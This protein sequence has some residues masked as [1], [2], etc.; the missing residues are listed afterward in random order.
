MKKLLSA[1]LIALLLQTGGAAAQSIRLRLPDTT[2]LVGSSFL[3][4]VYADS[5]FTGLNVISYQVQLNYTA[6]HLLA[7]SLI[8]AG[9]LSAGASPIA[10]FGS[11]GSVTVAAASATP[12][13]GTGI[14]FYVR[15]RVISATGGFSST[16]SFST[17]ANTYLNQGSPALSFRNGNITIPALPSI[18]VNPA[19]GL[20]VVGDTL[21]FSASGGRQP[22]SWR[23][24][25]STRGTIN[26]LTPNTARFI[27][28]TSGR[29]RVLATDSNGF[30]GQS[31]QE[32]I[33]HNFR[34]WTR[35]SSRLQGTELLLPVY[36]SSLTP[37]NILSGS[38]DVNL[39]NYPGMQLTGIERNGTLLAAVNQTFFG[40]QG[41]ASWEVSFANATAVTGSGIL[42]YLRIA[43]PNL[44][45]SNYS[46][47]VNLA[48]TLFNQSLTAL[49]IG[50]NHTAIA[51]PQINITPNTAELVAGENR[52]FTASNGLGA[53]RWTVSD[54]SLAT[55][56]STGLLSA[57]KGGVV[58]VTATDSVNASRTTGNIQLYDTRMH[59]RDTVLIAGDTL[60]DVAVFMD[61]L[62]AG[63]SITA[64]SMAFDFN[65]SFLQP[66]SILQT[67]TATAGWSVATNAIGSNRFSVA[68]AGTSPHAVAANLFYIRFKVLPGFT[69]NNITSL[70]NIQVTLNEGNPNY[71][72]VNGQIRSLPCTPVATVTPSGNVTFCSNQPTQLSGSSGTAYQY[73]WS[74]NGATIAGANSRLFTPTQS[75]NYTLRV[76]LNSSCF[77]VSDTVRVTINPSPIAQIL[78]YADT[79]HACA[80][81]TVQLR[82][83]REAGYSLQWFRNGGTISGATDTLLK[84]VLSGSY[85]VRSTLNGC[86]TT[87]AAQIVNIRTLPAKPTIIVTGSPTCSGDSA[88]LRIPA[89]SLQLQWFNSAGPIS[90]ATDTLLRVPA[91]RYTLRLTNTFGC[92]IY[93]DSVTVVA[94]TASA[95]IDP[96]GP[97]TFCQGGNVNLD[98]TQATTYVRWFRNGIQLADTIRPLSVSVSGS[99]TAAY[100]LVGNVCIFTTPAVVISVTPRPVVTLDSLLPVCTNAAAFTLTA[101]LPAGGTYVGPGVTANQ[102]NPASLAP[103]SY[104]I[105]YGVQ[106]NGCSDTAS[107]TITVLALPGTTFPAPAAV[108][109][110]AAAFALSG[111]L[112]A[113]GT[114]FGVGVVA[115]NFNPALA[116]VG[117]RSIGYTTQNAAGCRDTV[118]RTITVNALPAAVINQ[119]PTAA[120][121]Q[122]GNITLN[123][124]TGLGLVY[125]WLRN[126]LVLSGQTNA[127][128]TVNQA[129]NYRVVVTNASSCSDSSVVTV[130]TENPLPVSTVTPTGPV[131]FCQGGSVVLNGVSQINQSYRWLLNGNPVSGNLTSSLTATS[132]G[133]YRLIVTNT[134]TACFDT[135]SVVSVLVNPRPS[136]VVQTSGPTTL[137][138]G[139]SV[140]LTVTSGSG[141]SYQ[142][143]LNG[144]PIAGSVQ[145]T[146]RVGATGSYRAIVTNLVTSCFDTSA[147][148]NVQLN[149][150]PV[151]TVTPTG[152]LTFCQG[153]SVVLNGINQINQSY[154]WLLNG[155]PV[156][157]NLTSSLTAAASGAYRLIVTNTLTGCFDSSSVVNVLVN[158]GPTAVI[159]PAGA[160]NICQ[161]DSLSLNAN[162]G[163]GLNY[164]WLLNG[165]PLSGSTLSSLR[166]GASGNYRVIVTSTT[167]GCFDTSA[168]IPVLVNPLPV[169][170][171][172][173]AGPTTICA[174]QSVQLAA[175]TGT[176]LSYQW[177]RN[178]SVISGQNN[179]ILTATLAGDYRVVVSS[180]AACSDSSA[181]V[182]VTLNP[183]PD[184]AVLT[185]NVDTIFASPGT[186]LIWF[187]NG[188]LLA[189]ITDSVLIITLDGNYNALRLSAAGCASDSSNTLVV[190]N[191]SVETTQLLPLRLYPN[192][193][194]GGLYIA[195]EDRNSAAFEVEIRTLTGQLVRQQIWPEGAYPDLIALDLFDLPQA[196]YLFRL[197]QGDRYR[198]ERVVIQR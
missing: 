93:A 91:G 141:L 135:S 76:A 116:G 6:S 77:V 43:V 114:Y 90:G 179:A 166:V 92:Q 52:Q 180:A 50:S 85:T 158:P 11:S 162:S 167:T 186:D 146:L 198:Y 124:N 160:T 126:G 157:G 149:P 185:I 105:K 87:S 195:L 153:G 103:G 145:N 148:V 30:S 181:V 197:R 75:G 193:T 196:V 152:P 38:F 39:A 81:D 19:S 102:F 184:P 16:V 28:S 100:R 49:T 159:T 47:S 59:I 188:V 117:I 107:R 32:V 172:S 171:I 127:T 163:S 191:V 137:C 150:L 175:P 23:L 187:R 130:V 56:S 31:S 7:D 111:G 110:N 192:P 122:G 139:D 174:G 53:Y 27:A 70:S 67:A 34:M 55:I 151:S 115:G 60:V 147:I 109:V 119:G 36:V 131:T 98:L 63:K 74:R 41:T 25:D 5:S 140:T 24:S 57:R 94:A 156:A 88:T 97:T 3:L 161:G 104:T 64:I 2:A 68:L 177:L 33:V 40:Q 83:Y 144:S 164:Q 165:S 54:S 96:S 26:T 51:L 173:P 82:A 120:Y 189:G 190:T 154:R 4:P 66:Q 17:S 18:N 134:I 44:Y 84:A 125:Q 21:Q 14:L 183:L 176:G 168:I 15:F 106:Q 48:N 89:T 170:T 78:P 194:Q 35:D 143:L 182:T 9:T 10:N 62:P 86:V 128:L 45:A 142:W 65:S 61:Q 99:Y 69:V 133:N 123:A 95:Q 101:G 129:G 72:L 80:G 121:C 178:G 73:Q 138:A 8:S 37:W 58:T 169:A 20:M 13:S 22:Y 46:F 1:L 136:S 71:L 12:L 79:L 113:G 29:T 132:S 118:L 112:P 155:S 108:C 42:C